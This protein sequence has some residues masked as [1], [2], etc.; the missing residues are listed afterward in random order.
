MPLYK[1]S[2]NKKNVLKIIPLV[3]IFIC[4]IAILSIINDK[5]A[6]IADID[7]IFFSVKMTLTKDFGDSEILSENVGIE[8]GETGLDGLEKLAEVTYSY[9]GGFVESINGIKS[10]YA[11]GNG[12]KNDW[13]FYI[14]GMLSPI[15]AAEYILHPGDKE[16]WDYHYWDS[17]RKTTA[18]IA[19]YPEP[20]LHGFHGTVKATNIVYSEPFRNETNTLKTSLKNHGVT[21]SSDSFNE[22]KKNDKINNNLILIDT[23]DNNLIQEL[24]RNSATLGWFIEYSDEEL[25]TFNN[26]GEKDMVFEHAGFIVASQNP[27][28]QKGNWNGENVVWVISGINDED[29]TNA[30]NFLKSNNIEN[31]SSVV[32]VDE[33]IYKVP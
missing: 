13:F 8:A 6:I 22:L 9:S 29:V 33:N 31:Y 7:E 1:K 2:A 11:G 16:R 23:I 14:N 21:V 5:S 27:W 26:Y 10:T 12:E 30:V 19:D 3:I 4:L 25:N 15:G 17:D 32:I 24:N 28:N 18:I 20:F